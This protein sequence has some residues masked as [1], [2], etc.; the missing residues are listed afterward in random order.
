MASLGL[1]CKNELEEYG[2]G[3]RE[4]LLVLFSL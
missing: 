3:E 4:S 1:E 2:V